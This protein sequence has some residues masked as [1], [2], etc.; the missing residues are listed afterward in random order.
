MITFD[1]LLERLKK[2]DE[3]TLLEILD[4]SSYELVDLLESVIFDKQQRVRDYYGEDDSEL[5]G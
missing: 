2:E 5:G 1:D 4:I 3:L